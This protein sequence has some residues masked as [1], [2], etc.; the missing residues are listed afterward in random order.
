LTLLHWVLMM[1]GIMPAQAAT[2][3]QFLPSRD[4]TVGY[5]VSAPGRPDATYQLAYDA[6]DERARIDNPA[7]G[8]YFLVDLPG[9]TAQ[10]VVPAL[11]A[12]VNAPDLSGLTRQVMDADNARFTP[13]GPGHYAGMECE[14]YLV[15]NGQGSGTACITPDGVILHFTGSDAHGGA[16]VTATSVTYGPQPRAAFAQPDG[17]SQITLPPGALAQLLGQ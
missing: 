5:L 17:F 16:T 4:V 15:L 13:L 6:A 9:G 1:I 2:H 7:Q 10:L 12:V 11:H 8:D 3:P 14:K